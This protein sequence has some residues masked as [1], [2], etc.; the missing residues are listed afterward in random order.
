MDTSSDNT[1]FFRYNETDNIDGNIYGKLMKC[2]DN[3]HIN[4]KQHN[5]NQCM[6]EKICTK[7]DFGLVDTYTINELFS[8]L[9]DCVLNVSDNCY[10]MNIHS[11]CV[12]MCFRYHKHDNI[13]FDII[14]SIKKITKVD[15]EKINQELIDTINNMKND[16]ERLYS[17]NDMFERWI[18]DF[19]QMNS[20]NYV[21]FSD[22]VLTIDTDYY[23]E[24][25]DFSQLVNFKNLETLIIKNR[26]GPCTCT[27]TC[28]DMCEK[29][30][31]CN[32]AS[33][34]TV[35]DITISFTKDCVMEKF[36]DF[37]NFPNLQELTIKYTSSLSTDM[38]IHSLKNQKNKL[39]VLNL[40]KCYDID[41]D[42]LKE[43]CDCHLDHIVLN[44]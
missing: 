4:L 33:N 36:F 6:F 20:Q 27:C 14:I 43:F 10:D 38:L 5:Y 35:S 40:T 3:I 9:K 23:E 19:L 32:N 37:N 8:M 24:K 30:I 25:Y 11:D 1:I 39:Q 2:G 34:E 13:K 7:S 28:T 31:L 44:Y 26:I 15:H 21:D 29:S 22:E 41:I 42:I 16:I 17:K 18:K 12:N